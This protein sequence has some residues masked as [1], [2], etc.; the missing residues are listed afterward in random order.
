M[1]YPLVNVYITMENHH[2]Y[3]MGK[4]TI[5]MDISMAMFNSFL[6][7]FPCYT[8]GLICEFSVPYHAGGFLDKIYRSKKDLHSWWLNTPRFELSA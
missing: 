2:F 5:S 8:I 6:Y 7:V 3:I 4:S 1:L